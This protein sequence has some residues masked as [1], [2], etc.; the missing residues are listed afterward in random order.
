ML[1]KTP[2]LCDQ[3]ENTPDVSLQIVAPMFKRFGKKQ[4]FSG[5]IVTLKIFEDNSLV[6]EALSEN[7]NG[8]ILVVDGGG[9]MRCALLGDQL[10]ILAEKNGWQGVIVYGCIRDSA[11]IDQLD[12][13]VRALDTHP[14][15]SVKKGIGEKNIPVTFGGV[16]F[17]PG[18]WLCA[19]ADGVIVASRALN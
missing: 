17:T 3:F 12:I 7:G 6:R 13:G 1:L 19:D 10:G 9:S 4:A 18:H 2:D 14:K 15:K 11:D 5:K 16:T 8:Q